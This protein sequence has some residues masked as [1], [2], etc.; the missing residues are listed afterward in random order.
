LG[1][2]NRAGD[3]PAATVGRL[4]A[5]L[6]EAPIVRHPVRELLSGA[7]ARRANVRLADALYVELAD[8]LDIAL[9]T[10][11]RRLKPVRHVEVI[12]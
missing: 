6:A 5:R 9:V 7:W 3:L 4:L 8:Q 1:R 10:T 12:K 2:L 11:D